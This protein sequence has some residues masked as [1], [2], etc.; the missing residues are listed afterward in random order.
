MHIKQIR[1]IEDA[2]RKKHLLDSSGHDWWHIHRVKQL[3]I[4]IAQEENADVK[5][6][7]VLA[8]LHE[9]ADHKL[10]QD[11]QKS[12]NELS[13][14]LT[15]I[16]LDEKIIAR[17]IREIPEIS[18]RGAGVPDTPQSS[19]CNIV[20]DA[21]RLD[22]IGAIGIARTF[23]Y[24]GKHQRLLY[25]PDIKPQNHRNFESYKNNTN[26]T[27]NHF[28][29]K[30]LLLKDRMHTKTAKAIAEKRHQKMEIFLQDFLNEWNS[31]D[32]KH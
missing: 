16:E 29:E 7:E 4:F 28:Y 8:L 18:Y 14:F 19:E 5:Y 23:A 17:L 20:R 11:A 26:P 2:V 32:F 3:A 6:T 27:I 10:V 1:Q 21:D 24:G 25:H 22:A 31:Q 13:N 12:L 30:L 9:S 15:T